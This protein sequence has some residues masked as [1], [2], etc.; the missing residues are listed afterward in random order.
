MHYSDVLVDRLIARLTDEDDAS[1]SD[2][3]SFKDLLSGAWER[4]N[5][6]EVPPAL[7]STARDIFKVHGDIVKNCKLGAI[8][9]NTIFAFLCAAIT[10]M[11]DLSLDQV[12]EEIILKLRDPIMGAG[13]KMGVGFQ[14]RRNKM[15]NL[16]F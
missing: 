3:N 7:V 2:N 1:K 5:K 9:S 12:M 15:G 13:D 14:G 10:V 8:V 6:F 11:G 16:Q 4:V